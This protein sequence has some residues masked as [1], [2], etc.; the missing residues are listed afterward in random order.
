MARET[1]LEITCFGLNRF[2]P[3]TLEVKDDL[4]SPGLV[5]VVKDAG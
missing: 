2:L 1:K 4:E 3:Q 5:V